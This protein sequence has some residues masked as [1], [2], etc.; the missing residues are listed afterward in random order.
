MIVAGIDEAGYGPLLGP[1]VV[2]GVAFEVPDALAGADFWEVLAASVCRAPSRRESRLPITDSKRLFQRSA[3]LA[4]LER[5]ALVMLEAA[6][7]RP[8][9][10]RGLLNIVAPEAGASMVEYPWYAGHDT[11]LPRATTAADVATRANAVRRD[12]AARGVRLCGVFSEVLFEGHFN[13]QVAQTHNKAT[14]S[15]RLMLCIVQRV[16]ARAGGAIRVYVDRNGGRAHYVDKLMMFFQDAG[17]RVREESKTRS[18]YE[19]DLGGRTVQIEFCV[20][21]EEHHL[22]IALASVYSK[23]LRELLMEGLNAYFGARVPD[24]APTAGYYTDGQ[25]FLADIAAEVARTQVDRAL[26]VRAC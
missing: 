17:L 21:G 2:S 26:L 4:A 11:P 12:A 19:L 14:V 16:L 10:L 25:R 23:Y 7:R 13:R 15:L 8:R 24:L 22:P 5:T 6:G 20:Q 3:G 9:T 1:L 18:A